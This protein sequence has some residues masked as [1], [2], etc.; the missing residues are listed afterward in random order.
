MKTLST[1][2]LD[3]PVRSHP[4]FTDLKKLIVP[5]DM[6]SFKK[7]LSLKQQRLSKWKT[8]RFR[9]CHSCGQDKLRT[10]FTNG[11][12][13]CDNCK[14]LSKPK[15][16]S[17]RKEWEKQYRKDGI[18]L[19]MEAAKQI[20]YFLKKMGVVKKEHCEVCNSELSQA[21]HKDYN[22]PWLV[23]WLCKKHHQD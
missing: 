21:H 8:E 6:E 4:D 5:G 16:R 2:L 1:R 10:A 20:V 13:Y 18:G 15:R 19:Q 22:C 11:S 14:R 3:I 7:Y 12:K 23:T 9:L 17:F